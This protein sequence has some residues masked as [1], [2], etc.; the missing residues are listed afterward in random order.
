VDLAGPLPGDL[1]SNLDFAAA[2]LRA[3][4]DARAATALIDYLRTPDAIAV[5]KR[6][7]MD[8]PAP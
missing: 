5:I 6:K 7:G 2:T 4:N 1:Q 3:A 8:E